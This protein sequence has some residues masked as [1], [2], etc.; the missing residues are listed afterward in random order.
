MDFVLILGLVAAALTSLS[1]LPQLV[2]SI[3]KKSTTDLST[4]MLVVLI[5]GF[6]LW[7]V[8]GFTV[9]DTPIIAANVVALSIITSILVLKIKY[10]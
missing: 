2:K 1:G 9:K 6:I 4:L 5:I 3:K 7:L 10:R 8:Y